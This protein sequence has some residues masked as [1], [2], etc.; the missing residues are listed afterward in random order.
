MDVS[1]NVSRWPRRTATLLMCPR[2]SSLW[3]LSITSRRDAWMLVAINRV[4]I[5]AVVPCQTDPASM[6]YTRTSNIFNAASQT[7][8]RGIRAY[9]QRGSGSPVWSTCGSPV[10][11]TYRLILC[12]APPAPFAVAA[13]PPTFQAM[14][15]QLGYALGEL[16]EKSVGRLDA[17]S[18]DENARVRLRIRSDPTAAETD[19]SRSTAIDQEHRL[20]CPFETLR[21]RMVFR[22]KNARS[23]HA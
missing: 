22:A 7:T 9:A 3:R 20:R 6:Q 18:A 11:S 19:W 17:V 14:I 16:L 8:S 10:W 4:P 12:V 23:P 2:S 5:L 21:R 1:T 15:P 13:L